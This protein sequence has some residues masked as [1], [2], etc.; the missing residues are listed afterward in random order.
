MEEYS[1]RLFKAFL[2]FV[3]DDLRDLEQEKDEEK[4]SEKLKKIIKNLQNTL[5][6]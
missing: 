1:D 3:L 4:C 5:E 2:R 6:D